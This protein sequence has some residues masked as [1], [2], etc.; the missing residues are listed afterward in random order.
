MSNEQTNPPKDSN[1]SSSGST[2]LEEWDHC[3]EMHQEVLRGIYAYGFE[4][5]SPIQKKGIIPML[6]KDKKSEWKMKQDNVSSK[7]TTRWQDIIKV[8]AE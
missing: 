7:F 2:T 3:E 4:K 6:R 8:S 1:D 5:P